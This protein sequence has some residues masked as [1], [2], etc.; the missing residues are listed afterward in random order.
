[1]DVGRCRN[2]H[3]AIDIVIIRWAA[4][5]ASPVLYGRLLRPLFQELEASRKVTCGL[6][7]ID[8][9]VDAVEST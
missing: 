4:L 7:L 5:S 9:Q 8:D 1:M 6:S 3:T 2:P